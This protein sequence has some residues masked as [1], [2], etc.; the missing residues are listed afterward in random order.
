MTDP[1]PQSAPGGGETRRRTERG[2][3]A[4]EYA[5]L[6]SGIAAVIV[7]VVFAFGD[8]LLGMYDDTCDSVVSHAN[9]GSC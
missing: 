2:A 9:G 6:V 8:T 7:L 3:S 1:G 5:L 4:T